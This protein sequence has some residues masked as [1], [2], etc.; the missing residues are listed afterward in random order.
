MLNSYFNK[1]LAFSILK[2]SPNPADEFISIISDLPNDAV[3]NVYNVNGSQIASLKLEE[4]YF[5]S[6][7][8]VLSW[9]NGVY[10]YQL[11][12]KQN[13]IDNGRIVVQK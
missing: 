10:L 8:E 11:I 13:T 7:L 9:E 12:S 1:K 2:I 6:E 4:G 3:L 5:V